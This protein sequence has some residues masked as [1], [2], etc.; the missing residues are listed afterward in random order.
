MADPEKQENDQ[1]VMSEV[2]QEANEETEHKPEYTA[3]DR[4]YAREHLIPGE[5]IFEMDGH[6]RQYHS[7]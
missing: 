6:S 2:E 1:K 3:S 4:E 5:T 7:A